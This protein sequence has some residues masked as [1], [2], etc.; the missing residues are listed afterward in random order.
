MDNGK[1]NG[2]YYMSFR[3]VHF[4]AIYRYWQIMDTTILYQVIYGIYGVI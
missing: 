1:E 4:G 3:G 2:S